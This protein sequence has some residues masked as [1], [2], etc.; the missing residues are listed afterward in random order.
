M[1]VSERV[2]HEEV[3]SSSED[4]LLPQTKMAS[5]EKRKLLL[6]P[7]SSLADRVEKLEVRA[8]GMWN[9]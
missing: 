9:N 6:S 5:E 2:F 4:E 8:L 3:E 7:G 1:P